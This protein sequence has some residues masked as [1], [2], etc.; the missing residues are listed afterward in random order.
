MFELKNRFYAGET[1]E[2]MTA[3]GIRKVTA[4]GIRRLKTGEVLDTFGIAGERIAL[5]LGTQVEAGDLLRGPVR[6]H[7][8]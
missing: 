1:L 7:R 6:N 2:L 3:Q 5:G 4:S 8:T